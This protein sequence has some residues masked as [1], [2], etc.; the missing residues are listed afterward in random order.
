MVKTTKAKKKVV[1][2]SATQK[3]KKSKK[4][5]KRVKAKPVKLSYYMRKKLEKAREEARAKRQA[6][7][8]AKEAKAKKPK[9]EKKVKAPKE[10]IYKVPASVRPK[11]KA[12]KPNT[13]KSKKKAVVE[14]VNWN[15]VGPAA[16]RRKTRAPGP[17]TILPAVLEHIADEIIE[18]E[19]RTVVAV[20]EKKVNYLN[21]RDLLAEAKASKER[22]QMTDKFARM[23]QLL[24]AKYARKGN[25][26]N[27]SYNEDMQSYAM[28][29][30]VRTWKSFD[31]KKSSNA[32]AFFTQCIKNSYIQYLN[33]EKRQRVIRDLLLIDQG[34]NPSHGYGENDDGVPSPIEDEE[35]FESNKEVAD[36]LARLPS[37]YEQTDD[38]IPVD[39]TPTETDNH[40][41]NR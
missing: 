3:I 38:T 30:L 19:E 37:E 11:I 14:T 17:V 26:V 20:P 31:P 21:N 41:V 24:C 18:E 25:F 15:R 10:I 28:L 36:A 1:S 40:S 23:L 29:M 33:Q 4:V 32:F 22:D 13:A 9:K 6:R 35:D 12:H 2:K 5:S 34:L 39:N 8:T 27:Y 7:K 16:D